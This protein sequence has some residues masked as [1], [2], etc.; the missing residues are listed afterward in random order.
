M[1][2]PGF[3]DVLNFWFDAADSS[4]QAAKSLGKLWFRASRK[5]DDKIKHRFGSLLS[6]GI[7]GDLDEWRHTSRGRLALIIVLD[8]FSRNIFRGTP[9]AFAQ[10]EHA[11]L[12]AEEGIANAMDRSLLVVERVFFYM[13]F[14]HAEN[15]QVQDRSV[16][17]FNELKSQTRD[18]FKQIVDGSAR[19]AEEHRNIVVRF[20]RFPHRNEILRRPST[21]EELAFLNTD[22][23]S[24]GQ[25]V[26]QE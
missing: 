12:L 18:E 5:T 24:Y 17:L 6:Q 8:Q 9:M 25:Y 4:P 10:D 11:L 2:N 14:Q 21:S 26:K 7:A 16:Q 13:P 19:Y 15:L 23:R 3:E 22:K 1:L 20:G